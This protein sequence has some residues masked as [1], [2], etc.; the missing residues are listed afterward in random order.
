MGLEFIDQITWG[1]SERQERLWYAL[2]TTVA[3][4]LL[5]F[6]P[7][8]ISVLWYLIGLV[9][10][11]LIRLTTDFKIGLWLALGA[12]MFM[13]WMILYV[14]FGLIEKARKKEIRF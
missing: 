3:L 13:T 2:V 6:G 10:W 4:A 7:P 9:L 14:V 5:V 1:M 12:Y 8:Q 11:G